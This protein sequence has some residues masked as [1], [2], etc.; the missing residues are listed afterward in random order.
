MS[1]RASLKIFAALLTA[2]ILCSVGNHASATDETSVDRGEPAESSYELGKGYRLGDSGFTIGG[3]SAAQYQNSKDAESGASLTHLSMFLWWDNDS[4]LKF[5]SELD[6]ERE[7]TSARNGSG[8]TETHFLAVERF[9]LDYSFSDLLTVRGGKFLTPVGRWNLI[10]ADPLVWTTSRPMI[11]HQLYPDNITGLM[12]LGNGPMF[13]RQADYALY[14]SATHDL[15][16]APGNDPFNRAYGV[17]LNV[18][19]NEN[20]EFGVSY[21]SFSQQAEPNEHKHLAGL[22]FLWQ[23]GGV[24]VSGEAA[25]RTSSELG[26]TDDRRSGGFIQGVVPLSD[27]LFGVVRIEALSKPDLNRDIRLQVLGLNYRPSRAVALK[28]E[29]IRGSDTQAGT[30]IGFLSSVSVLF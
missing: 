7:T 12:I 27:K 8:A 4:R 22:D 11:T 28:L 29:F 3:Y 6:R 25:Y 20:L 23:S 10:H 17:R 5:F 1:G 13:G 18:P 19:A 16:T 24:E 26:E 9:Y 14:A 30:P 15:R 2:G 21:L